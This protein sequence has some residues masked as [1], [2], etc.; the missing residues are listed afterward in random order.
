MVNHKCKQKI[1]A[2]IADNIE[3]G[4]GKSILALKNK[5]SI[6]W[7]IMFSFQEKVKHFSHC[8]T[9]EVK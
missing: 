2:F 9:N 8:I 4:F 7:I 1:T 6:I 3:K 5:I